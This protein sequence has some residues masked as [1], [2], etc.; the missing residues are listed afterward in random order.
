[1]QWDIGGIAVLDGGQMQTETTY[2][3]DYDTKYRGE[4][5]TAGVDAADA[6]TVERTIPGAT[7][8]RECD[9]LALSVLKDVQEAQVEAEVTLLESRPEIPLVEALSHPRL[10]EGPH[11]IRGVEE[12][13]AGQERTY[14][15]ANRRS[16]DEFV[17][18]L[19]EDIGALSDVV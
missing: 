5:T 11:E 9:Q 18:A 4:A 12:G 7:S 8:D 15:L 2:R 3:A 13:A 16:V 1:M 17:D 19:Q 6:R 14:R 10:P